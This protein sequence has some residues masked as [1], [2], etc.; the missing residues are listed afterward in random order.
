MAYDPYG[1]TTTVSGTVL[2]TKQYAGYYQHQASGVSLTKYRGYDANTGRWLSRGPIENPET[3]Q[4]PNLYDYVGDNSINNVDP[5]GL[6]TINHEVK[7]PELINPTLVEGPTDQQLAGDTL[8]VEREYWNYW[9]PNNPVDNPFPRLIFK[10]VCPKD[11]PNYVPGSAYLTYAGATVPGAG[12][13]L[14]INSINSDIAIVDV[15]SRGPDGR[16]A[17]A[18]NTNYEAQLLGTVLHVNC[19]SK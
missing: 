2:P 6:D 8:H 14:T 11:H 19:C 10:P 9:H 12:A 16:R 3:S 5:S 18:S 13:G 1:R 4:G 17:N 7:F 15:H